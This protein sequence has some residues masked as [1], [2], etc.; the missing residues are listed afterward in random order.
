[1]VKIWFTLFCVLALA[2][3]PFAPAAAATPGESVAAVNPLLEINK[4]DRVLGKPDAPITIIEYASMTCPHC[5]H[6]ANEVLPQLK[7]KWIDT[8]KVKL[9]LRDFPL[10]EMALKASMIA[11]CAPPGRFYAFVDTMF[12]TQQ[13][14]VIASDPQAALAR[15]AKLGGMGESEIDACLKNT[16]LENKIVEGRL[17][18]SKDLNVN[19][20]P[21]FF[22]N[23]TK[24]SGTP[25]TEEFDKA[26]S[27]LAPKS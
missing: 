4:D 26:L 17:V 1:M 10:D 14:W 23:G 6:F 20:T 25:T 9:V 19:A 16:A 15:I 21:T 13:K 3:L 24:F 2:G 18:A 12:A 22:I 7:K 27:A 8:G 5:A 11:R